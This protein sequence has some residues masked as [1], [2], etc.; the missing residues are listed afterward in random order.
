MGL[1]DTVFGTPAETTIHSTPA[2]KPPGFGFARDFFNSLQNIAQQPYPTFPGQLD[3]GLSPTMQEM[4]RRAQGY[5]ESG[6][7]EILAGVQGSLGRFMNP[8]FINPAVRLPMGAPDMI[9]QNPNQRIFGGQTVGGMA[10]AFGARGPQYPGKAPP[11]SFGGN[12]QWQ[13]P[14]QPSPGA[15]M[16]MPPASFM[17]GGMQQAP[18]GG[19][20]PRPV[21]GGGLQGGPTSMT[22]PLPMGG[23]PQFGF[24]GAQWTGQVPGQSA[25]GGP[26]SGAGGGRPMTMG[27]WDPGM[28]A[29]L[30][31]GIQG[32]QPQGAGTSWT[33]G[34]MSELPTTMTTPPPAFGGNAPLWQRLQALGL[35]GQGS[36]AANRAMLDRAN[37]PQRPQG[38]GGVGPAGQGRGG[39]G[40]PLGPRP[41]GATWRPDPSMA[42]TGGGLWVGPDGRPVDWRGQPLPTFGGGPLPAW[43]TGPHPA[44]P[45]VPASMPPGGGQGQSPGGGAPPPRWN[46]SWG[47]TQPEQQPDGTWVYPR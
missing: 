4:I 37:Q 47:M 14:G 29:Q 40:R 45:A 20:A 6:P 28:I 24:G 18:T 2:M 43:A 15:P 8:S 12:S 16:P 3:P 41:P 9:G 42:D 30:I 22:K 17:K 1:T 33:D 32:A 21:T 27:G 11:P 36:R 25:G 19:M 44:A 13:I 39:P 10:G 46:P 34:G 7:P 35:Q 31:Q 26:S 38:S 23:G 5:S